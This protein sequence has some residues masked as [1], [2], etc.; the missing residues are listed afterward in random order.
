MD[1]NE[2]RNKIRLH[3]TD[4]GI[5]KIVFNAGW[6]FSDNIFRFIVNMIVTIWLARH[7]GPIGF[8]TLNYAIAFV[9]MFTIFAGLG[10]N[11]V[12]IRDIVKYPDKKDEILGSAF[13]LKVFGGIAAFVLAILV[14]FLLKPHDLQTV[15]LVTIIGFGLIFQTTDIIDSF[16]QSQVKAKY[17]AWSGD[18]AFFLMELLEVIFILTNAHLSYFA[19]TYAGEIL[20]T[21]VGYFLF[22]RKLGGS[23]KKWKINF[24]LVKQLL[25]NS[26]SY[27]LYAVF[28]TFMIKIDKIMVGNILGSASLGY[29][30]AA[31]SLAE[32]W[33]FVPSAITFSIFPALIRS[34]N[35]GEE[36][37]SKRLQKLYNLMVIISVAVAILTTIFAKEMVFLL[38]G[39]AYATAGKILPIYI[40]SEVFIFL[41]AASIRWYLA[42]NLQ[43]YALARVL[44]GIPISIILNLL[45]IK[46]FGLIGAA[47]STVL[48]QLI[49]VYLLSAVFKKTRP[50]FIAH[51]KSF[52]GLISPVATIKSLFE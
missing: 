43:K 34:K 51:S 15:I 16:F 5:K 41:E 50:V 32:P 12:V 47:M 4:E 21:Q 13:F 45:L 27:M 28:M 52:R 11:N 23:I 33:I 20:L 42:E 24:Q 2:L 39:K 46:R 44:C 38:Y 37:Y 17:S 3:F 29:Y 22:Y 7:L 30:S 40:W 36:I 35:A 8:G 31:T 25:Q 26:W 49:I 19:I 14:I 9:A 6:I 18:A 48:T 1:M 10:L